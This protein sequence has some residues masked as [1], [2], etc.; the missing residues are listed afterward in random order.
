MKI[1][2][3]KNFLCQI[4]NSVGTT[5]FQNLWVSDDNNEIDVT[6]GGELSC[7]VYVTSVLKLFDLLPTQKA[8]V[9]NTI[10]EMKKNRWHEVELG[11]LK[12]GDVIVWNKR[13]DKNGEEHGHIGFYIGDKKAVSNSTKLKKIV[14]HGYDFGGRREIVKVLRWKNW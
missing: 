12:A 14:R 7:A 10:I 5:M 6:R 11:D 13:T 4:N 3:Y 9:E 8:T 1:L 2:K